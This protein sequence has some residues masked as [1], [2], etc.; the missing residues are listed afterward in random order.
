MHVMDAIA[1]RRTIFKFKPEPV[2]REVLEKVFEAGIW[3]P[4]HLSTEPWRFIVLGDQTKELLGQRYAE[5][6]ADKCKEDADDATCRKAAEAGYAKFM[7]KPTIVAVACKQTGDDLRKQEDYAA[8]CCAVQNVQ[9]AAWSEG[10]GMQWSTGP[11][12]RERATYER[13]GVDVESEMIIGFFYMG[14]P[15]EVPTPTRKP[16]NEVLVYTK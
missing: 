10:V 13:L 7:S 11:I 2:S 6:Q 16:L 8:A 3:A 4:N 12:T 14:T 5:I 9:L 1:S 15:E